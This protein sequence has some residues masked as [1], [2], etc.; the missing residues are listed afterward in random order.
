MSQFLRASASGCK[1]SASSRTSVVRTIRYRHVNRSRMNR[2]FSA[3]VFLLLLALLFLLSDQFSRLSAPRSKLESEKTIVRTAVEKA[4]LVSS[5]TVGPFPDPVKIRVSAN[6]Q[7][8]DSSIDSAIN[9]VTRKLRRVER[10]VKD[11]VD[12]SFNVKNVS[13][14]RP[15]ANLVT[16][17]HSWL[18]GEFGLAYSTNGRPWKHNRIY[19]RRFKRQFATPRL[20]AAGFKAHA[21]N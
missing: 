2:I 20:A 14:H 1:K 16:Q 10:R 18:V 4:T 5:D 3:F 15:T 17:V 12:P 11:R 6:Y 7:A 21:Q 9:K 8:V 19:G 13:R